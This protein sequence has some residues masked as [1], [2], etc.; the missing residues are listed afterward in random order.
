[1]AVVTGDSAPREAAKRIASNQPALVSDAI[2][3][4]VTPINSELERSSTRG[5]PISATSQTWLVAALIVADLGI[6]MSALS[7]TGL[8]ESDHKAAVLLAGL[9][10]AAGLQGAGY[11]FGIYDAATAGRLR[12]SILVV[13]CLG[14][15][16]LI[17]SALGVFGLAGPTEAI[18]IVLIGVAAIL[19]HAVLRL[20]MAA[21]LDRHAAAVSERVV[22]IGT[23]Q[24]ISDLLEAGRSACVPERVVG[25]I[26]I[27]EGQ[28]TPVELLTELDPKRDDA[29]ALIEDFWRIGEALRG[30][31]KSI[32]RIVIAS[33]GLDDATLAATVARLEH[34]PFE[35]ALVPPGTI[36]N[37]TRDP[38][39]RANCLVLRRPAMTKWGMV[40][41]RALDIAAA[42]ALLL[43]L[44]PV[45]LVI[46]VLI[47]RGSPGPA[48][49]RQT[50]WGWNNEPFMVYKFRTMWTDA[51][52]TDGS[53]Q[54]S[55]GDKRITPIG[56][57]LRSTS[58]DELPQL[59][60]VLNGT[61]SLVGPRPHPVELNLRY[62]GVIDRY[63]G[64][65]RVLPGITG[66][67]QVKGFRGETRSPSLM[68]KRV[69]FDLEYIRTRSIGADIMILLKTVS[70]VVRGENA[71]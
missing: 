39:E 11:T 32:D 29:N 59:L 48:L 23:S 53:V 7:A 20:A 13:L 14:P 31:T 45:L 15:L 57:F 28:R 10:A 61:M 65:H 64:R 17:F 38:L 12:R 70:S 4:G 16:A 47:R 1:M 54:A 35:M 40:C 33:A 41:K 26:A 27:G 66:L 36:L 6:I 68:Q 22:L 50:R 43:I 25:A 24:A 63:A 67:A 55:R 19:S 18:H 9:G 62:L 2:S 52:A 69:E 71:Y 58:L 5:L 46:A 21:W 34:L 60:N 30:H 3:G 49:F 51:A 37:E 56:A 44:A 8:F 42:S